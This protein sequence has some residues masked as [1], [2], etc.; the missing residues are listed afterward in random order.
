M[1]LERLFFVRHGETDWNAEGRLQGQQDIGLNARGLHQSGAAG[2]KL[3]NILGMDRIR[4]PQLPYI[5]S[6]LVR[7]RRTMEL[8]RTAMQLDPSGYTTDPLL[9]ELS[10]GTWEGKTWPEVQA[11]A[12][13][14]A[15]WREGDKW[16]FVPPDGE[17]YAMLGERIAPWL[18][19]LDGDCVVVSHGGV[20]RVLMSVLGGLATNRAAIADIWQGR[21]IVFENGRFNWV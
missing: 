3:L 9:M 2:R 7:A 11:D 10:F 16:N 17:S 13:Q 18:N 6:P 15:S 19:A 12:P 8:A 14:A 21:V 4:D 20:A 5:A 1:P